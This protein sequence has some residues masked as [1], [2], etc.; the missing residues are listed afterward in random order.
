M[1]TCSNLWEKDKLLLLLHLFTKRCCFVF[2]ALLMLLL[3]SQCSIVITVFS[4]ASRGWKDGADGKQTCFM[5]LEL[6]L[7]NSDLLFI[8]GMQLS[9]EITQNFYQAASKSCATPLWLYY[10][11]ET[12]PLSLPK[13]LTNIKNSLCTRVFHSVYT[14]LIQAS[15]LINLIFNTWSLISYTYDIIHISCV[16]LN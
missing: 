7:R 6:R 5:V 1:E 4:F 8:S 9:T 10:L 16:V 15:V 13:W 12:P 2:R 11:A 14:V 3:A